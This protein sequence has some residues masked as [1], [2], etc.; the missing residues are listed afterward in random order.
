MMK[1]VDYTLVL[2]AKSQ[3]ILIIDQ[4]SNSYVQKIKRTDQNAIPSY[5]EDTQ[6]RIN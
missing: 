5:R 1:T 3:F 2:I 4:K 6:I